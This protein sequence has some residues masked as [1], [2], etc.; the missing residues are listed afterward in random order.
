MVEGRVEA[1]RIVKVV[2]NEAGM[3]FP[4]PVEL[5]NSFREIHTKALMCSY[6]QHFAAGFD[7]PFWKREK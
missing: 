3:R 6:I 4:F 2:E 7:W 5:R 1:Q